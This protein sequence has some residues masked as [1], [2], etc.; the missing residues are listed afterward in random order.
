M[1]NREDNRSPFDLD[2]RHLEKFK[3]QIS[4]NEVAT[5]CALNYC[6]LHRISPPGWLIEAAALGMIKLLKR[7]RPVG[8]G[9]GGSQLAR[10]QHEYWDAQRWEKV[11]EVR[12]T[13]S[14]AKHQDKLLKA[15]SDLKPCK[16]HKA[17]KEWLKMETFERA[18]RLLVGQNAHA[19][20]SAIRASYRRVEKARSNGRC[21]QGLWFDDDFLYRLGV[22]KCLPKDLVQK[23][24]FF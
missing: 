19:S 20:P 8:R 2:L 10:F 16:G 21:V 7:E 18:A 11:Q 15:R 22:I 23:G 14:E 1:K 4:Q 3:S 12:E 9:R 6:A 17:R 5:A 24:L 13:R